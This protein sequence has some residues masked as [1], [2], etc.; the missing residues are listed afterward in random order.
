MKLSLAALA[1][2]LVVAPAMAE[3]LP[4]Q[5]IFES[6][7]ISGPRAR[8]V[9]LSPDGRSVTYI[10]TRA[11]DLTV[12][13]LW[14]ADVAGGE[15]R[16]LLDGKQ[17]APE[18]RELSEA[19]KARRERAG[20]ATRGVV[21]YAWDDQGKAILAPVEG[22]VWVYDVAAR[23]A[24]RG[25]PDGRRRDRRQDLAQG[26]LRLL[27]PG[28]Q[29][30]CHAHR[31]R[32]RARAD[33]GRDRAEELGHRRVHRPGGD[34]SLHRLLVEP[35]RQ[36]GRPRLCRPD[37]RRH[38]GAAGGERHRRPR[39]ATAIP[40]PGSPECQGRPLRPAAGRPPGEGGSRSRC[41][42][43]PGPRRLGQGRQ[44]PLRPAPEP[45]PAPAGPR[46]PSIRRPARAR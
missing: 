22:D 26:R 12:T 37:R 46:W 34:G 24:R 32:G 21:D 18:T 39:R 29:P 23:Q 2:L 45:R 17:L 36:G 20:V 15:P 28:R 10:K 33:R 1:A 35:G 25:H 27:R 30:L 7:D 43:L 4:A 11:D 8:G 13:D 31:G 40:P 19:E 6:P 16:L 9:K 14:I 41:R 5:R 3:K 44:D 42:H 38:R